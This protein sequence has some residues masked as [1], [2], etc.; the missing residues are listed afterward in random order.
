MLKFSRAGRKRLADS[1]LNRA[2]SASING[3]RWLCTLLFLLGS[4][5]F[6]AS[7]ALAG[8]ISVYPLRVTMDATRNAESLTVRNLADQPLLLQPTVVKW[9]QKDGQDIFEPTRDI[10]V[11]PALIEVPARESQ[12]VRLSLRRA[13][14]S[15]SELSYRIMLREVPK[16]ASG[17]SSAIVIALNISLPIFIA[18][19]NGNG[20]GGFEISA[21]SLAKEGG[22]NQLK[23]TLSNRGKT[24]IQIKNLA[25]SES[26]SPLA[27][28]SKMLY[29]L[30]GDSTTIN[31]PVP[32]KLSSKSVRIDAQTDA[33]PLAQ[34]FRLP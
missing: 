23:M 5:A 24:H 6:V 19:A 10:L 1:F 22:G 34:E 4:Q 8:N 13:P 18:P 11:S 20:R 9:S 2:A 15:S 30:P 21:A 7:P 32:R 3:A 12:V 29:I 33:G 26:G 27:D 28:Y 14:D 16:P 25:L 17:T 31:V